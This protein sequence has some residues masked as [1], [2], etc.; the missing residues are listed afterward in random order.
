MASCDPYEVL[1]L[2]EN[3]RDPKTISYEECKASYQKLCL[4]YHPDKNRGNDERNSSSKF[5]EVQGAW[6]LIGSPEK[7]RNFDQ[8]YASTH[9][10]ITRSDEVS[11][12]EFSCENATI[13]DE[14]DGTEKEGLLY[15]KE[16]RCG[17]FYEFTDLDINSGFNTTQCSGC[18][19]YCTVVV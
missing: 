12:S 3:P 4:K 13:V 19:L 14:S 11:L 16:C 9:A 5:L 8:Q 2:L 17:D 10:D 18:S 7:K 6:E 1:G 15:R